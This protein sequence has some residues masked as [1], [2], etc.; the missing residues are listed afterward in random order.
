MTQ[1]SC[2]CL[3]ICASVAPSASADR[4]AVH[5]RVPEQRRPHTV[6]GNVATDA[7]LDRVFGE[8]DLAQVRYR[9]VATTW[10]HS[11]SI[12]NAVE[13][14]Y[15]ALDA[16]SGELTSRVRRSVLRRTLAV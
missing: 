12:E 11:S 1:F 14:S 15:F 13:R 7:G 10:N 9:L 5:Y 4:L 6:I 16:L 3:L 2:F 8:R